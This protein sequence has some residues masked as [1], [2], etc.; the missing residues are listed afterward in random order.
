MARILLGVLGVIVSVGVAYGSDTR[1]ATQLLYRVAEENAQVLDDPEPVVI[2][3]EF[4]E[5][6]LNFDLRLFVSGLI[7]YR[8]LHHE[9]NLAIDDLFREHGIEIAFPQRDLHVRSVPAEL[10]AQSK[11]VRSPTIAREDVPTDQTGAA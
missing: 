7:A 6:S 2:F 10:L 5:S 9:L 8:R 4:G 11:P 3:R 1:L